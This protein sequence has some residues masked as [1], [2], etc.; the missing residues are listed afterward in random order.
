MLNYSSELEKLSEGSGSRSPFMHTLRKRMATL[1]YTS[2]GSRTTTYTQGNSSVLMTSGNTWNG[3]S[4]T[5]TQRDRIP[6]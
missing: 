4:R 6:H 1:N 2:G 5:T 3:L